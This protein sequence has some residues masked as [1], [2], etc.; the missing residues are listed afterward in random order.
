M[1]CSTVFVCTPQEWFREGIPFREAG[2]LRSPL[3]PARVRDGVR[4][5]FV[6]RRDGLNPRHHQPDGAGAAPRC[7]CALARGPRPR[8]S[9]DANTYDAS[10]V[11]TT[12][13]Q[14]TGGIRGDSPWVSRTA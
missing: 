3:L 13:T 8:R 1:G 4:R 5:V 14:G 6:E 12:P 7:A 10:D 2:F 9:S 11:C